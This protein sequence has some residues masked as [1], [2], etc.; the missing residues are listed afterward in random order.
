MLTAGH[1]D[2][3]GA[4]TYFNE[5]KGFQVVGWFNHKVYEGDHGVDDD[6]AVLGIGNSTN[7]PPVPTDT[8]IIGI[9]PVT[10]AVDDSRLASGQQLCH[11]GLISGA[12]RGGPE[13]GPIVDVQPTTVRFRAH[14][15]KG[16]SGGPVYYRN[17]DGT[18]TPVGITIRAGE[19]GGTVAELIDPWM[20][21]WHLVLDG[22]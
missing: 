1:C 11:Y 2:R 10:M 16:D 15:D 3:D 8:R 5:T 22:S 4:V 18:A 20:K 6:I 7:G 17:A 14:V 13:C 9:R 21:R 12:R 19:A